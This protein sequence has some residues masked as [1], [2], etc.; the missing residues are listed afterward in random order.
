MLMM[1]ELDI[2]DAAWGALLIPGLTWFRGQRG[3]VRLFGWIESRKDVAAIRVK[4]GRSQ[5]DHAWDEVCLGGTESVPSSCRKALWFALDVRTGKGPKRIDVEAVH[6]DGT[7]VRLGSRWVFQMGER[8]SESIAGKEKNVESRSERDAY[9]DWIRVHEAKLTEAC[10][11]EVTQPGLPLSLSWILELDR[12]DLRLLERSLVSLLSTPAQGVEVMCVD[13]CGVFDGAEGR[14]LARSLELHPA[15]RVFQ[16]RNLGPAL[17]QAVGEW[18]GWLKVG[19]TCSPSF[20]TAFE[21]FLSKHPALKVCY[22]DHDFM[23]ADGIRRRPQ[24]LPSWNRDLLAS[25]P[26]AG[27]RFLIQRSCFDA[28]GGLGAERYHGKWS[29]MLRASRA[30]ARE[31]LGRMPGIHFHLRDEETCAGGSAPGSCCFDE[32]KCREEAKR[33]LESHAEA[34]GTPADAECVAGGRAWRLRYRLPEDRDQWP[35]VSLL[36]PTRDGLKVL[37][38]CVESLLARTDY[39]RFELLLLDNDS[40]EPATLAYFEEVKRRGV[41]VI[42]CPGPFNFSAINNR[43][44]GESKG[45]LIAFLNNDLEVIDPGWLIELVSHAMRPGIGAVGPKL[46]YPDGTLQHAGVLLGV[47]HVAAHAFRLFPNDPEHGPLRAH[48][49]QNYSALTAAC[50]LMKRSVFD[51]VGGYDEVNLAI[52]NNDV[53]LCIRIREAGYR[54]LYTPFVSLYHHESATRGPED[55]PEKRVRYQREVDYM[56]RRWKGILLDDPAY[57]PLLTR[58]SE[59]FSL[60]DSE[61]PSRYTPGVLF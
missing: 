43:G 35:L 11:C 27:D 33:L 23:G 5:R 19:D 21:G 56:W 16:S 57:N 20:F 6:P 50:L 34:M 53:D 25:V 32:A 59:S 1:R 37:S 9:A 17:S 49:S 38:T 47:G 36:I 4:V 12:K 2:E 55:T 29:L 26:Y 28:C 60:A 42:P 48:L 8:P 24:V 40:R 22:T 52:T 51:Q 7:R 41:R 10:A 15:I 61:Q 31:E 13:T 54:N 30:S 18:M 46:L 39:P 44:V 45:S 58:F 3:A 14:A